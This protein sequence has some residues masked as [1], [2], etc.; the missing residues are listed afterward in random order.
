[1]SNKQSFTFYRFNLWT[2]SKAEVNSDELIPTA[3]G[4]LM[5]EVKPHRHLLKQLQSHILIMVSL[6][7]SFLI[8]F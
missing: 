1:M 8:D 5:V 7:L 6:M 4:S 2:G 3:D